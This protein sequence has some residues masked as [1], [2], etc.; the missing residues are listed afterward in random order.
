MPSTLYSPL[1]KGGAKRFIRQTST[2][3]ARQKPDALHRR[4]NAHP[5]LILLI[6]SKSVVRLPGAGQWTRTSLLAVAVAHDPSLFLCLNPV[7]PVNPV[8]GFCLFSSSSPSANPGKCFFSPSLQSCPPKVCVCRKAPLLPL[9]NRKI[10]DVALLRLRFCSILATKSVSKSGAIPKRPI[11]GQ[12][13]S[14]RVC[15]LSISQRAARGKRRLIT[16]SNHSQWLIACV[17]VLDV[18]QLD[19]FLTHISSG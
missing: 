1:R 14:R 9:L 15:R 17:F 13:L 7:N 5:L 18:G 4:A 19:A 16:R 6:R 12:A 3:V 10:L 2:S 8:Q 11:C